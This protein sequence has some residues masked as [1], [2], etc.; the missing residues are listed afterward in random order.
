MNCQNFS[1]KIQKFPGIPAGNF[2]SGGFPGI[3]EWEFPVALPE[4]NLKQEAQLLLG[5]R[6]TRKHAKDS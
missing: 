1:P 4:I 3:P 2:R 5:D 6:A